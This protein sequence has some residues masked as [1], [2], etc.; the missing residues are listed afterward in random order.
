M[1]WQKEYETPQSEQVSG[2]HIKKK[3]GRVIQSAGSVCY[4]SMYLEQGDTV[5]LRSWSEFPKE[6]QNAY[7]KE[8]NKIFQCEFVEPLDAWD[9]KYHAIRFKV[10]PWMAPE[11]LREN[12][13]KIFP[14]MVR[15]LW[16]ETCIVLPFLDLC[17]QY[18]ELDRMFLLGE[19]H[20]G[21][22]IYNSNHT[23]RM[24]SRNYISIGKEEF[25]YLGKKFSDGGE[26]PGSWHILL[27]VPAGL[28]MADKL[29]TVE[30]RYNMMKELFGDIY[31]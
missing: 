17:E 6:V 21:R 29:P 15:Y 14:T 4:A 2:W 19:A 5:T 25:L 28:E 20:V 13:G 23:I 30:E 26:S 3:G 18:P 11:G 7:L 27:T 16:E 9:A 24:A 1:N 10:E 31:A 22:P 12:V 8:L